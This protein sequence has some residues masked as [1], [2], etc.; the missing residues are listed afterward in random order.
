[1]FKKII[2]IVYIF[3]GHISPVFNQIQREYFSFIYAYYW[4]SAFKLLKTRNHSNHH[5]SVTG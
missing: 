2:F 4:A 1:M 5:T 3:F